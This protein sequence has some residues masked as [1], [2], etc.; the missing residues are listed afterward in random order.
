LAEVPLKI[1]KIV[2][3]RESRFGKITQQYGG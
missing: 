1:R 3:S 2:L